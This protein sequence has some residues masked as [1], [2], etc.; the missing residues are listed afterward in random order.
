MPERWQRELKRMREVGPTPGLWQRVNDGPSGQEEEASLPRRRQRVVAGVVA[1]AVFIAAG[2]FAWN[3]L[4]PTRSDVVTDGDGSTTELDP[5]DLVVTL[6][7]P[8]EP[9]TATDLHLPTAVFRL[10][11]LATE[12]PTQ[13]MT[14][15]PDIPVNGFNQPLYSLDFNVPAATRLVIQG[16]ATS[17]SAS[18][19]SGI[20]ADSPAR[21]FDLSDGPGII[22]WNPGQYVIELTGAWDEGTATF[23]ALFEVV[24]VEEAAVLTFDETDPQVPQLSLTVGG[25]KFQA[26]LGTHHWTFEGGDG[27]VNAVTPT[28]TDADVV[29]V[30]RGTPLLLQDAPPTVSIMAYDGLVMNRGPKTDLSTPGATFDLPPGRYLVVVDS[31]WDDAQA[32]FWLAI[33]IV[34]SG[35][36]SSSPSETTELDRDGI[37]L[38]YPSNWTPA[39]EILTPNLTDPHEI[40]ALGTYPLRSGGSSCAQYPMNAIEDLGPTDALIWFAERQGFSADAPPRPSDFETWMSVASVDDS[41]DCLSAPKDF[42]HHSAEFTDAGR[43]FAFYVAYGAS[44]SPETLS[45][46]WGMLDGMHIEPSTSG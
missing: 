17:A 11:E 8:T 22:L 10:G 30:A 14:G 28:F 18:I 4:G 5:G 41:A 25:A 38:S 32:E 1:F 12:I 3:A 21:Q 13:G 40:L 24:P 42:V 23:T 43:G 45:E 33:E 26:I 19:R 36:T 46:L 16:D 27:F 35:V 6:R 15:W 20:P 7:A 9:S 34:P 39:S 37:A 44:V 31:Q 2:A 29:Q